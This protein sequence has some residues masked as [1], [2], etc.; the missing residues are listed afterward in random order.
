[1]LTVAR[2]LGGLLG[3]VAGSVLRIRRAHVERSMR[4]AGIA[5]PGRQALAMYA[6]LGASAIE[7]LW[8]ALR[9]ER[10]LGHVRIDEASRARWEQARAAGRGVGDLR[11]EPREVG[12]GILPH[13][14][15]LERG[16]PHRHTALTALT[17]RAP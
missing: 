14:V 3:W 1:M 4:L 2:L 16:D 9:G 12:V 10:A 6:S 13:D 17:A 5:R 8:L 15:V 11:R 7:F